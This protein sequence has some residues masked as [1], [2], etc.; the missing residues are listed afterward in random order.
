MMLETLHSHC[1]SSGE[2]W[3]NAILEAQA[4][5][6]VGISIEISPRSVYFKVTALDSMLALSASRYLCPHLVHSAIKQCHCWAVT[7][8]G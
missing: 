2:A 1:A 6:D 5:H 3:Q 8:C 4:V 7:P